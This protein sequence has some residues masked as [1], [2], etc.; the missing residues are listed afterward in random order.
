MDTA[1]LIKN[2]EDFTRHHM[3]C[4]CRLYHWF[5]QPLVCH[6]VPSDIYLFFLQDATHYS[7][8][9]YLICTLCAIFVFVPANRMWALDP[10]IRL[11]KKSQT[12]SYLDN[13]PSSVHHSSCLYICQCFYNEWG[14]D[15]RNAH[16]IL[17]W[18]KSTAFKHVQ[19]ASFRNMAF[20][21]WFA[22]KLD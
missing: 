16:L 2:M 12:I 10:K 18:T 14:L 22:G 8:Y 20:V 6:D 5:S 1:R 19:A 13:T 9:D 21:E 17:A 4:Q 7:N 15:T 3:R 11:A